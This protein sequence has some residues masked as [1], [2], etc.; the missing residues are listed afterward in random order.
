MDTNKQNTKDI[1]CDDCIII[2]IPKQLKEE[3]TEKANRSYSN[4]SQYIRNII[5]EDLMK[6]ENK[7]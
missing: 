5:V 1:K 2:K 3:I 6:D 4:L 7:A